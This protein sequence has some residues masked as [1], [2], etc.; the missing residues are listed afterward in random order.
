MI[1]NL[2]SQ[3]DGVSKWSRDL[4]NLT[5]KGFD[6][7]FVQEL[8][9]KGLSGYKYVE[10]MQEATQEQIFTYNL[11]YKEATKSADAAIEYIKQAL[12]TLTA[13]RY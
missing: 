13:K 2:Q 3:L 5:A 12:P 8:A 4:Q 6:E 11:M 10:A 1:V 7:A 9:E